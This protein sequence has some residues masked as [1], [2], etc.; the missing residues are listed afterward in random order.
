MIFYIK[1]CRLLNLTA[2]MNN[3]W[4]LVHCHLLSHPQEREGG[5]GESG[6]SKT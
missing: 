2:H 5:K 6:T 3:Y 1:P 4:I